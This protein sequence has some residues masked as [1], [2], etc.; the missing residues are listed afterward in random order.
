MN[1]WAIA[2][3]FGDWGGF[4][5]KSGYAKR[6]CLGWMAITY[7]PS[8]L[9]PLVEAVDAWN[10]AGRPQSEG[11]SLIYLASP[12]GHPDPAVREERFRAV[13]VV[14]ARLMREGLYVFSPI[15]HTHPIAEAGDL[16]KGWDFWKGYDRV[17]LSACSELW[18]LCLPGWE[19]SEGVA[20]EIQIARSLEKPISF[21]AEAE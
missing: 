13:C 17:M 3:S 20:A 9:D 7:I 6:V 15:A 2:L 14:A 19:E 18:V 4:Y 1:G 8:D 16:P 12:Y 5:W 11:K 21:L 10:E